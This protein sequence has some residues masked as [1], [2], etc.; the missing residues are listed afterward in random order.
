VRL[1]ARIDANQPGIVRALR[2]AG[3]E[4]FCTHQLGHGFPDLIV[5][6]AMG[7]LTQMEIKMFGEKLTHDEAD[8]RRRF[9]ETAVVYCVNDAIAAALKL[10]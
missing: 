3:C 8:Y 7:T 1:R 4:V 9:P 10:K 5:R 6:S 2:R